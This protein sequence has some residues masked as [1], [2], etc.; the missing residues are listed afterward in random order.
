ME[1]LFTFL[2]VAV[3]LAVGIRVLSIYLKAAAHIALTPEPV[4]VCHPTKA[5]ADAVIERF[6]QHID[7][8]DDRPHVITPE[9]AH[10]LDHRRDGADVV[11]TPLSKG[12]Y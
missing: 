9:G 3:I 1:L 2:L 6:M 8:D 10:P 11:G 7:S 5:E 4:E 12:S